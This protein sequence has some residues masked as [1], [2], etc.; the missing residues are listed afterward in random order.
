MSCVVP[1]PVPQT[2]ECCFISLRNKAFSKIFRRF[3]LKTDAFSQM[4]PDEVDSHYLHPLSST[5]LP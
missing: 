2:E 1:C 3:V 5:H 4:F